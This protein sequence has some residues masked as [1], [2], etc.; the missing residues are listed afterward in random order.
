MLLSKQTRG[1][2]LEVDCGFVLG[3][4]VALWAVLAGPMGIVLV[5]LGA[6]DEILIQGREVE[7][8]KDN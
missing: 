4:R 5:L 2:F 1:Y 7:G 6:R 3:V 8:K